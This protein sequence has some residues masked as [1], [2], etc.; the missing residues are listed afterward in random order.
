MTRRV[1]KRKMRRRSETEDSPYLPRSERL[2]FV[3][4]WLHWEGHGPDN[5]PQSLRDVVRVYE[6]SCR[7]SDT[8]GSSPGSEP[9]GRLLHTRIG[10]VMYIVSCVFCGTVEPRS[11]TREEYT[12]CRHIALAAWI[13]WWVRDVRAVV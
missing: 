2:V 9:A 4:R 6:G 7:L 5:S 8:T 1:K 13:G 12:S 11:H 10:A 3:D